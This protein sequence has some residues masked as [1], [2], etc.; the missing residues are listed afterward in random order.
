MTKTS[1]C[2]LNLLEMDYQQEPKEKIDPNPCQLQEL[3]VNAKLENTVQQ[4]IPPIQISTTQ[5]SFPA[6]LSFKRHPTYLDIYF[7]L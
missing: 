1:R 7:K 4:L 6:Q 2:D 5:I 3:L